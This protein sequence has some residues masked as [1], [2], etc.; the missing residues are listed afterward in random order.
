MVTMRP[1]SSAMALL[2]VRVN[3]KGNRPC[4]RQA[5]PATSMRLPNEKAMPMCWR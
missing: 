5:Q 3:R 2:P 1:C 4:S